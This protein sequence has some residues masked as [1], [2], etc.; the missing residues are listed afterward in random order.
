MQEQTAV[1]Y[2]QVELIP[3]IICDGYVL[4]DGMAVM[5]ERGTA[6][7]LGVHHKSL[8][9]VAVNWPPKTLKPFIN[10]TFI[11]AVN[12]VKVVTKNSPH[13][14]RNINVYNTS[15]I[16]SFIRGYALALAHDALR[17]N[18][19]HIGKRCVILQSSLVLTALEAAIKQACGLSPNIQQIVQQNY[20]ALI[21]EFGFSCS[22]DNEIAI[23]KDIV[24]FLKVPESTLNSFLKKHKDEIQPI[25]LD[26]ATIRANGGKA[27]RMNGY[28]LEDVSKISLGMDS[29]IGIALKKRA[30]GHIG[31]IVKPDTKG[32]IEW[33]EVLAK[34]F[35]GFGFQHNY[36]I[37]SYR[38]DFFVEKLM[39]VLEC[40]GYDNH[41]NYDQI[42]E[43]AREKFLKQ[44]YSIIRFHHKIALETLVNGILQAKIGTVIKLYNIGHLYPENGSLNLS[45]EF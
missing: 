42:K 9:S 10:K 33:Q 11:V 43:D 34:V 40:N 26:A 13:K 3:G 14:G 16:E 18:Q 17:E 2:G 44:R 37:G 5:S 21:K 12:S 31:T 4:N 38:V 29:V 45:Q 39:L 19:K 41:R 20:T 7:L 30:F 36:T 15:F 22:F 25:K 24:S 28:C 35:A 23:K 27:S 32:E 1:H 8:Q 6:D